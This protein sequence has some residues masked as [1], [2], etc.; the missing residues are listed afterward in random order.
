[1]VVSN[2]Q[3]LQTV[4][5]LMQMECV[6]L[7]LHYSTDVSCIIFL[8]IQLLRAQ[9]RIHGIRLLEHVRQVSVT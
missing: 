1:M 2:L 3:V 9:R 6:Q 4:Q 7:T 5:V 8:A